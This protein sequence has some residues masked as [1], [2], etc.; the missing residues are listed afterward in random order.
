MLPEDGFAGVVC[1][2]LPAADAAPAAA[3]DGAGRGLQLQSLWAIPAAAAS[4]N[5]YRESLV[6]L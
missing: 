5:P 3:A 2:E 6:Q 4:Y 1:V